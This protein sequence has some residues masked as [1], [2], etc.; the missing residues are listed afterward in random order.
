MVMKQLLLAFAAAVLSSSVVSAQGPYFDFYKLSLQWPASVCLQAN[1]ITPVPRIF[2]IH[3]LWSTVK[4]DTRV[5]PYHPQNNNCY[6]G[7]KSAADAMTAVAPI[8]PALN[9]KW[10]TLLRS[11][12]PNPN[13]V[14]WQI[15]WD[16]HGMCSDYGDDPLNYFTV[17]LN[18][19]NNNTY[20]PFRV[21][22]VQPSNTPH[23][24]D[25]LL[26]NAKRNVGFYSQI[27]C[28]KIG[29]QLYL[30]EIRYCFKRGMPP[31]QL[32]NC[33]NEMDNVC[34]SVPPLQRN[35]MI[36]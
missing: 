15:E 35:L 8:V 16:H 33:P 23:P 28:R 30:K 14:F 3:G 6:P 20:D 1:C 11:N 34:T 10:P 19:A 29:Q 31:T 26:E 2:T 13:A 36:P 18:L 22:G 7:P 12:R 5:Y 24:I 21:M 9:A 27:S 32:Q 25:T 17:T 4:N